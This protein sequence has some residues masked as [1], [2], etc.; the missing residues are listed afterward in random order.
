MNVLN[1]TY[2]EMV[3][4]GGRGGIKMLQAEAGAAANQNL[5]PEAIHKILAKGK[6]EVLF[7]NKQYEDMNS[8]LKAGN[9]IATYDPTGFM[10][11]TDYNKLY[12]TV[13]DG[14]G[15]GKGENPQAWGPGGHASPGSV[16]T[17][18]ATGPASAFKQMSDDAL[19]KS[20]GIGR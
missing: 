1:R 2:G 9:P 12:S 17:P 6:T 3:E 18:S 15:F 10:K 8:H 14:M 11:N 20:L 5:Q 4:G 13:Y 16:G 19:L 7:G